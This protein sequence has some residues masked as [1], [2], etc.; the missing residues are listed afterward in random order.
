MPSGGLPD[1]TRFAGGVSPA[2]QKRNCWGIQLLPVRFS[3][4]I[5][6][7]AMLS[8]TGRC[9]EAGSPNLQ[10]HTVD[11]WNTRGIAVA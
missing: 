7:K 11:R 4:L 10:A 9:R 3:D 5:L 6:I 1:A 2:G 8:K